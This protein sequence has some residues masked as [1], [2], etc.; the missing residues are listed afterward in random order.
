MTTLNR[1]NC[2][3]LVAGSALASLATG[4]LPTFT[5]NAFAAEAP[6]SAKATG[7]AIVIYYSRSGNTDA[8][9]KMIAE[10]TGAETLRLEVKNAY[11]PDYGDMTYI[12]RDEVRSGAR[13]ELSTTIPYLSAYDTVFLG[14][15]YWW[16]SVSVPMNTFL[17]DHNLAGKT[18]AP[19]ITSGSS[20]PD[21]ALSRMKALCP[22]ANFVEHFYVPGS[23]AAGAKAD[24]D[25]WLKK[26]GF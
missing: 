1:R 24:I 4:T 19:F 6:Q 7:K 21:G 5:T 18:V 23:G 13:R 3:K 26:L 12:A 9:A 22:K 20:S 15:P 8:L 14:T 2:L 11:A 16:G 17:L 25:E 10:R